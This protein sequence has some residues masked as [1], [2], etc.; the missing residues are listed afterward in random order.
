[1]LKI[2]LLIVLNIILLGKETLKD[3]YLQIIAKNLEIKGDIV[4]AWGEVV[5]Y[6]P[7]YYIT[8]K[9]LVYDKNSSK[10]ELFDEVNVLKN[11][12][13]ISY[14]QYIFMDL[15]LEENSMKP[16]LLIDNTN[17]LWFNSSN[18]KISKNRYELNN[19][20]LSSCDCKNPS[21]SIG[22]KNGDYDKEEQWVNLYRT[23]LYI[24]DLP[25]WY[26]LPVA[27]MIN[28]IISIE[29]LVMLYLAT[30]SP[31]IGFPT[32]KTRRTGILRPA[33][34]WS[35]E[36]GIFYAQPFYIAPALNYDIEIVPQVRQKRGYGYAVKYRYADS[37][38]S[39]LKF[40]FGKFQEKNDYQL[41]HELVNDRHYGW[42]FQ[43]KREKLFSN[44]QSSD[45]LIVKSIDMNDVDY[46]NT[47]YDNEISNYTNK[48]LESQFKY[49]YN[50]NNYYSDIDVRLY[51]DISQENNDEV[52]QNKPTI[53]LHKYST[54]IFYNIF[55]TSIDIKS[56]R[57]TRDIGI[58]AN[59]TEVYAPITYHTYLFNDYFNLSLSEQ[60]LFS[61]IDYTNNDNNITTGK[62][63]EN[64]HIISLYTDLI[65]PY[66][67]YIHSINI[68][69][70]YTKP[71]IFKDEGD[72]Y[73]GTLDDNIINDQISIFPITKTNKNISTSMNQSLYNKN[74]LK[75]IINHKISQIYNYSSEEDKYIMADLENDLSFFFDHGSLTNRL[76][77]NHTINKIISTSTALKLTYDSYFLNSYYKSLLDK[78]TLEKQRDVNYDLGFSFYK[79]YSLSYKNEY[80][81]TAQLNKKKEYL[82]KI[83]KKC[84]AIDFKLVDSL[85]ATNTTD[86]SVLRQNIIYM[87]FNF[88]QLAEFKH[89]HKFD[90]RKV[91]N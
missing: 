91:D 30:N 16:M 38:D 86:D 27:Y 70:T 73:D 49:F 39:Q 23:T 1:M 35:E 34:G 11:N 63:G 7:S 81:L 55:T 43:Y 46:I 13:L 60:F 83:D 77:Y 71:N 9:K 6:S 2:V 5:V 56:S 3:E 8:A 78:D 44:S 51:N 84:W 52:M 22:F 36:E 41:E 76:S 67:S 85:V 15:K 90:E 24:Q 17:K 79:Y 42:D 74:S 66:D 87:N 64:N 57:K 69:A 89:E 14:S 20:T 33:I 4:T 32:D 65:K 72:I 29:P 82:F 61:N 50:T 54:D 26:L 21:W 88:K 45:G 68:N 58:G 53:N 62:Y 80:D 48:F 75:E 12:E 10:L 18:T 59:T 40:E 37:L 31:Y 19:S 28:P 47:K 25:V